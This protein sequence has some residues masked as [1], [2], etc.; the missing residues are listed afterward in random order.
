MTLN[1]FARIASL[2]W[3]AWL[4]TLVATAC[5]CAVL[6]YWF[7]QLAAPR[8]PIAPALSGPAT[9]DRP[10][11]SAA[12]SLFGTPLRAQAAAVP[13]LGNVQ[14]LGVVAAGRLGSAIMVVDGKPARSFAVGD[15]IGPGQ[16]VRS[17]RADAVVIDDNGRTAEVPAPALTSTAVLTSGAGKPRGPTDPALMSP[18]APAYPGSVPGAAGPAQGAPGGSPAPIMAPIPAPLSPS[19]PP[20]TPQTMPAPGSGQGGM[21]GQVGVPG[22]GLPPA[23]N[24]VKPGAPTS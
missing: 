9:R 3:A 11:L 20:G 17:V 4:A 12:G 14:V 15:S 24:L 22:Q 16:R 8:A 23:H 5:L 13:V 18:A 6:A 19:L 2:G 10:D 1:P 7:V 21:P